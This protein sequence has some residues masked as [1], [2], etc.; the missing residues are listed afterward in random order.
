M[1]ERH[2]SNLWQALCEIHLIVQICLAT[3]S[4]PLLWEGF[5]KV[6]KRLHAYQR[7]L[8]AG[9]SAPARSS[10]GRG[11]AGLERPQLLSHTLINN[12]KDAG[13][14]QKRQRKG[15]FRQLLSPHAFQVTFWSISPTAT[16][17]SETA[18]VH[19]PS[20]PDDSP[21]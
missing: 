5:L 19:T 14:G 7:E 9:A 8:M 20:T 16:S 3:V 21:E 11:L 2:P 18:A 10:R 4:C 1:P 6:C 13:Q 12:Y 17:Y 15:L